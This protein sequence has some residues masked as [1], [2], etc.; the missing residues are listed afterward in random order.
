VKP[1]FHPL[2]LVPLLITVTTSAVVGC[3]RRPAPPREG[4]ARRVVAIAPNLAE[5]AADVG[6]APRLVGISSYG[7]A[8]R[9]AEH[10]ARVGGFVDPSIE[11]IIALRPD[12]VV[13]VP[14]QG[15]ALES[16]RA[17][18]LETRAVPC[19]TMDEAL[20]AYR[21]LGDL[22][23]ERARADR[24]R[25]SL[26]ARLDAVRGTV[27]ERPR[28]RTLFLLGQAGEDF[29]QVFPVPPG[30]FC[31]ELLRI[32]GGRNVIEGPTPGVSAESIITLAPE[33]VL[34]V[35]MDAEAGAPPRRL[36]PSP[37]WSRLDSVP[38]V[39]NRRVHALSTSSLLVPGPRMA[40]GAELVARLIHP[41]A[42][43]DV[44]ER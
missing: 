3:A 25:A 9:G 2:C 44:A 42:F 6:G 30:N 8:P 26:E 43:D 24:A 28:P 34:E 31:D 13:G 7:N 29:Q 12:L 4:P 40:E 10:V 14:L 17:A 20:A 27:G 23:G 33:V 11:R 35:S 36:D 5:I 37:V 38:A 15:T 32:A 19:A 21:T 41:G 18:G 1:V 39:R 16:C 22:L